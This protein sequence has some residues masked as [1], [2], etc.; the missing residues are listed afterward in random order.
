MKAI[1]TR[2][3]CYLLLAAISLH[4][5]LVSAESR[6]ACRLDLEAIP[7]FLAENDPGMLDQAHRH[8]IA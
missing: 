2:A 3:R 4:A 8:L 1:K 6:N 5:C 7:P